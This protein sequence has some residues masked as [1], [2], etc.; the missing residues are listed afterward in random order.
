[1]AFYTINS[2]EWISFETLKNAQ[3]LIQFLVFSYVLHTPRYVVLMRLVAQVKNKKYIK[4]QK[5][6]NLPKFEFFLKVPFSPLDNLLGTPKRVL[7]IYEGPFW[8]HFRTIQGTIQGP[9][10]GPLGT[11]LGQF[12]DHFRDHLGTILGLLG[13]IQSPFWDHFGTIQGT[14]SGLAGG[15]QEKKLD[16]LFLFKSYVYQLVDDVKKYFYVR[17]S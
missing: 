1:M 7:D 6:P 13:T 8:N 17:I 5:W 10:E 16:P 11:I 14:F 15:C 12:Q 9:F 2:R 3:L 4:P